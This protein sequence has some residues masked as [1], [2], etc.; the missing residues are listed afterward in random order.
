M[1]SLLEIAKDEA[2]KSLGELKTSELPI[3]PLKVSSALFMLL[4]DYG[5]VATI[6]SE[7][8]T[9]EFGLV[10]NSEGKIDLPPKDVKEPEKTLQVRYK[11]PTQHIVPSTEMPIVSK[12]TTNRNSD[13]GLINKED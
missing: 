4:Q 7:I 8:A 6:V 1:P 9:T 5:H 10:I 12:K 11:A 2:R 13:G 3:G